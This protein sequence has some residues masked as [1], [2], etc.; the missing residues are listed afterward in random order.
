M[1]AVIKTGGKQ[2]KVNEGDTL[3]VEK[4]DAE[5][6]ATVELSDV[7][8]LGS[9]DDIQVGTPMI[10]GAHVSATVK[11]QGRGKKNYY[12]QVQTP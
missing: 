1:Y 11:E 8:M 2:Y 12:H 10:E 6:G 9:G 3:R 7:L 5:E 4:L